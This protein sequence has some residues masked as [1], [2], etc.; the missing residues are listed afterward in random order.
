[1]IENATFPNK[2][3]LGQV[4]KAVQNELIS[5]NGVLPLTT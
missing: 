2:T 1:M 5:K 4:G 3:M